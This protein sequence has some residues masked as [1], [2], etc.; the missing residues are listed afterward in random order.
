MCISLSC[1]WTTPPAVCRTACYCPATR[2]SSY[3]PI[4]C[5]CNQF[6]VT[7]GVRSDPAAAGDFCCCC[8][9]SSRPFLSS[10]SQALRLSISPHPLHL[11]NEKKKRKSWVNSQIYVRFLIT[12]AVW[13]LAFLTVSCL[14]WISKKY[15]KKK[16]CQMTI[17][18][19]GNAHNGL[20]KYA[21]PTILKNKNQLVLLAYCGDVQVNLVEQAVRWIM[22]SISPL[23][24]RRN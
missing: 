19:D 12:A 8:C 9:C 2:V 3:I 21:C 7:V 6:R 17:L 4:L 14:H 1:W 5:S 10:R 13:M 20:P 18:P 15:R 16:R 22:M 23:A 11:Q 24:A